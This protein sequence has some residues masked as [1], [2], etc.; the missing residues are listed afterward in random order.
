M[1]T[2]SEKNSEK[3]NVDKIED[4]R[5]KLECGDTIVKH[6]PLDES[7]LKDLRN[8]K[9][10][11]TFTD[12]ELKES[13][14]NLTFVKDVMKEFNH[15][16]NEEAKSFIE[17]TKKID[18]IE[19]IDNNPNIFIKITPFEEKERVLFKDKLLLSGEK[20]RPIYLNIGDYDFFF[21]Y[22]DSDNQPV[23][24]FNKK[25]F[26]FFFNDDIDKLRNYISMNKCFFSGIYGNSYKTT[27]FS[28]LVIEIIDKNNKNK[29]EEIKDDEKLIEKIVETI[30][31]KIEI[32][33]KTYKVKFINNDKLFILTDNPSTIY[34][35]Y[36]DDV[37]SVKVIGCG[38]EL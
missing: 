31:E 36:N 38:I 25:S 30:K 34:Q 37:L 17:K 35:K 15:Y 4:I 21:E 28:N 33:K 18:E 2:K 23:F 27:K 3:T 8:I 7:I 5:K 1:K 9:Q 13:L 22:I 19:D 6:L 26:N 32:N 24:S 20:K 14:S 16:V 11:K 12:E 29:K 10:K